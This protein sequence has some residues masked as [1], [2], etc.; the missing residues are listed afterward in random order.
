[1]KK[2]ILGSLLLATLGTADAAAESL[3][4]GCYVTDNWRFA[5][6]GYFDPTINYAPPPCHVSG[7]GRY[8]WYDNSSA[9]T[10][11]LIGLYGAPVT[12]IIETLYLSDAQS[13]INYDAWRKQVSLVK[14]L[15]RVCGT[16]CKRIR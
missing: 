11:Q 12:A 3:P 13:Q 7:D 4:A 5:Y 14:K 8:S 10:S 6:S 16:R 15:R 1:M 9:T 2:L